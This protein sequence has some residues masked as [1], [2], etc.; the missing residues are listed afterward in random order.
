MDEDNGFLRHASDKDWGL[1]LLMVKR[2]PAF[3][4]LVIGSKQKHLDRL[5]VQKADDGTWLAVMK[6]YDVERAEMLVCFGRGANP[7]ESL[8]NLY[9]VYTV[10]RVVKDKPYN[11]GRA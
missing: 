9:K 5:S 6:Y 4:A 1:G 2:F 11:P 8:V 7:W 10:G 3:K